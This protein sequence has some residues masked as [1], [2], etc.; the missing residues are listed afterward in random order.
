MGNS[1]GSKCETITENNSTHGDPPQHLLTTVKRLMC[2]S[3]NRLKVTGES[4][5]AAMLGH[6]LVITFSKI[7]LSYAG[8]LLLYIDS[9]WF[10]FQEL[11][12]NM[13]TNIVVFHHQMATAL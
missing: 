8:C 3:Y 12:W 4:V 7:C 10:E 9:N 1:S 5:A 13:K 11:E 6:C 2:I